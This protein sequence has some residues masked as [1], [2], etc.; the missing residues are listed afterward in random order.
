MPVA[1]APASR[2]PFS[3]EL[4][5]G[6]SYDSNVSVEAADVFTRRGDE[7]LNLGASARYRLP[8]LGKIN[9]T[10]GYDFDQSLYEDL[11]D[12]NLQIHTVSLSASLPLGEASF[13]S[14]YRYFHMRLGNAPFLD[15]HMITPAVGR[16]VTRAL[17]M[18][19]GYSYIDK[20]FATANNLDA[21]THGLEAGA[22]YFFQKKRGYISLTGRYE[23][24]TTRDPAL[25]YDAVQLSTRVQ[26]ATDT[27][28]QDSKLRLSFAYRSR[29]YRHPT[30]SLGVARTEKRYSLGASADIPLWRGFLL[31]P[32]YRWADRNSN[33]SFTNYR[34][35]AGALT[36][37][38]RY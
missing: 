7:A 29:D 6:L 32:E 21:Q 33:Y 16:F 8:N 23:G 17:Y 35:N 11:K 27:W 3:L 14:D 30:P 10:M 28:L 31:R 9:V 5:T 24:E 12:Y 38:Y 15:M 20:S 34:E 1:A 37:L 22:F 13:S 2:A 25:S 26:I 18:R 4:R 36:L 19:A